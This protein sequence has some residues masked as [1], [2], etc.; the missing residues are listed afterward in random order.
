MET[1]RMIRIRL[2]LE[3]AIAVLALTAAASAAAYFSS[4]L[5]AVLFQ[6]LLGLAAVALIEEHHAQDTLKLRCLPA[7]KQ[8][9][10]GIL[11]ALCTGIVVFAFFAVFRHVALFPARSMSI[12]AIIYIIL[13]QALVGI[14]EEL[15]FR[16]YLAGIGRRLFRSAW[17]AVI[18]S[19]LIF[20]L[21]HFLVNR[22]WIQLCFATAYGLF[23]AAL[24]LKHKSC[25]ILTMIIMHICYN[26]LSN[27]LFST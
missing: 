20:G 14:S 18:L 22:N 10:L 16:G 27:F 5:T 2:A 12:G 3:L 8:V 23:S 4:V 15:F 9:G 1:N 26:Y 25:S 17:P 7:F 21:L 11:F 13:F 24:Y 19:A 6:L